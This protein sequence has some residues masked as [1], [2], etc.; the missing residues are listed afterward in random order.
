MLA[1]ERI[2]RRA[3]S[4]DFLP[5]PVDDRLAQVGLQGKFAPRLKVLHLPER[6]EQCFLDKVIGI[7]EV[8]GPTWQASARPSP[9]PR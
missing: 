7:G 6:A 1:V 3:P 4:T 9:Q 8:T 2:C 5:N